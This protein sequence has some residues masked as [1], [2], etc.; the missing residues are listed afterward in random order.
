MS[1]V[2]ASSKKSHTRKN[3]LKTKQ[4]FNTEQISRPNEKDHFRSSYNTTPAGNQK[5]SSYENG[6]QLRNKKNLRFSDKKGQQQQVVCK[7]YFPHFGGEDCEEFISQFDYLRNNLC[8]KTGIGNHQ[9][10]KFQMKKVTLRNYTPKTLNQEV[11]MGM[12][13]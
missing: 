13:I 11:N 5:N 4:K 6:N 8:I 1:K 10:L 9:V 3:E 7:T 2:D 12:W